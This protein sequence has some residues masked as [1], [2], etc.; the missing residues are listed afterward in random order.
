MSRNAGAAPRSSS[1]VFVAPHKIGIRT[2][3]SASS[4][5]LPAAHRDRA[6]TWPDQQ[7]LPQFRTRGQ[8]GLVARACNHEV[9]KR[10]SA[11]PACATNRSPSTAPRSI[12][13]QVTGGNSQ[14]C[15]RAFNGI[16]GRCRSRAP[17]AH[18]L[19]PPRRVGQR[20]IIV[21]GAWIAAAAR[22]R[23]R[24]DLRSPSEQMNHHGTPPPH[25]SNDVGVEGWGRRA[26]SPPPS[27]RASS[28]SRWR[29]Q[30]PP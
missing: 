9:A 27:C 12:H 29:P 10:N 19:L 1:K 23:Y 24:G 20:V 15:H 25:V 3:A 22:D 8:V 21:I 5:H 16:G 4:P 28:R 18:R 13:R 30:S 14:K 11:P 17:E 26:G 7:I 2:Q 6:T